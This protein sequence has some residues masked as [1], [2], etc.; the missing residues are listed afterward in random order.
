MSVNN[1]I[2]KEVGRKSVENLIVK[3]EWLG[4]LPDNCN[5]F[6]ALFFGNDILAGAVAFSH[7]FFGGKYN[8]YGFPAVVLSRGVTLHYAPSW[9]SSFLVSKATKLLYGNAD[10]IFVCGFSDWRAG[11][12]G[13]IYQACNWYY[14]GHK[15]THE[16][17][18]PGG[19]RRDAS[20]HKIRVVSGSKHRKT[21][22]KATKDQYDLEK[23]KMLSEGW[24]I[25]KG[26]TRGRY[27]TVVGKKGKQ[28][29]EM[30]KL[31][32]QNKQEYPKR[33]EEVSRVTH[34][35]SSIEGGVRS[36]DSAQFCLTQ[37]R[38]DSVK[39]GHILPAEVNQSESDLPA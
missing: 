38:A 24:I 8:L 12:I 29:R 27:C 25:E 9:A 3:Y 14:L 32:E 5:R 22:R 16:W 31:L 36:P 10:P 21:G 39:A 1:A 11:E 7:Q 33:A 2:V 30:I 34:D 20:F 37:R 26:I 28:F 17:I 23:E 4:N 13:T 6:A 18:D 15:L 19:T 35:T